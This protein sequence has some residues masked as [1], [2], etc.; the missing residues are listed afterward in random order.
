MKFKTQPL[1]HALQID[2][3]NKTIN[4]KRI[5]RA[6]G[7]DSYIYELKSKLMFSD[8]G[9]TAV[10][11]LEKTITDTLD[12]ISDAIGTM[13]TFYFD[14]LG[15]SVQ[16]ASVE[17]WK[18]WSPIFEKIVNEY[19]DSGDVGPFIRAMNGKV[20]VSAAPAQNPLQQAAQGVANAAAAAAQGVA[21]VAQQIVGNQ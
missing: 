10:T 4:R 17:I 6:M 14:K 7:F 11:D 1:R 13:Y 15:Y 16:E 19:L 21:N 2:T 3:V 20:S 8:R 12:S 9:K 5:L 18:I